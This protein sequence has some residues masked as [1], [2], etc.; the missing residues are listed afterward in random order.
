MGEGKGIRQ[1]KYILQENFRADL[2][3]AQA[4]AFIA[5]GHYYISNIF[6]PIL[7]FPHIAYGHTWD[8]F[9]QPALAPH[10][11]LAP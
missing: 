9:S 10:S 7:I 4:A 8:M 11:A 6:L 2:Y 5:S 3:P 1:A